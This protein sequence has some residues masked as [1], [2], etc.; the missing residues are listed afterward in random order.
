MW[1]RKRWNLT[2]FSPFS[3]LNHGWTH[4]KG[5]VNLWRLWKKGFFSMVPLKW[6]VFAC[7]LWSMCIFEKKIEDNFHLLSSNYSHLFKFIMLTKCLGSFIKI[8]AWYPHSNCILVFCGARTSC[9]YKKELGQT[10]VNPYRQEFGP[11]HTYSRGFDMHM[12]IYSWTRNPYVPIKCL[13]PS[14]QV[15]YHSKLST[16]Q[17]T[18]FHGLGEKNMFNVY[19]NNIMTRDTFCLYIEVH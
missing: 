14:L 6:V 17:L 19:N 8:I 4:L 11:H 13:C 18:K 1:R 16:S 9:M 5:G 7:Q 15:I 10:H 3:A 2:H 12:F